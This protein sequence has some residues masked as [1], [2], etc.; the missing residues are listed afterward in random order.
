MTIIIFDA[1]VCHFFFYVNNNYEN[2]NLT[3]PYQAEQHWQSIGIYQGLQAC[4]SFHVK[5]FLN[6]YPDL[7]Q[8]YVSIPC[9]YKRLP[10]KAI[11]G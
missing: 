3:T 9:L 2:T 10:G 1:R 5:Q 7:K 4:G 8:K 11:A 6:N